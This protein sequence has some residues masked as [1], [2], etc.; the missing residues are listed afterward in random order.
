MDVA[1]D[2]IQ[3]EIFSSNDSSKKETDQNEPAKTE[4]SNVD[5][6][7]E[8]QETFRAFSASPWGARIGGL[9]DNVRKQSESYYEGAR[10]E[11]AAASEEAV[12]GFSDLRS[13]LVGRTRGLSLSTA[14]GSGATGA[15]ATTSQDETSTPTGAASKPETDTAA[16]STE[17]EKGLD[18]GAASS[19]SKPGEGFLS[20]FKAEAA[21]RLKEIEK[22]EE[23]ADEAILRFGMNIGQK[24]RE[25]V[26]IVPPSSDASGDKLL[27]ESKDAEGKRV[28]HATRFEAQL[29]VIH[30]TLESFTND[31]V[32][33]LWPAFQTEFKIAEKTDA[34]AADLEKYPELR[35]AMEKLVPEQVEYAT[36]W[37]RY[38]FL[39]LVIE[40]EEQ[41]RK[42][43]LQGAT[44][45]DD[46][47][48]KWDD[49]SDEETDSPSTPQVKSNTAATAA[50]TTTTQTATPVPAAVTTT[51]AATTAIA[52]P[53]NPAEPRRSNDQQSQP[54][55]ESSYDLV[56]GATSRT[57]ASPKE[58]PKDDDSD[59]DWE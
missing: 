12:K 19:A 24:L 21:R 25:A 9:W 45:V 16:S 13:S 5:L 3:E 8:L 39:R 53:A 37:C 40:T 11:Y 46:E 23:A 58:K 42:E 34:I 15:G 14:F 10:Q 50:G 49:D 52:K 55:S 54:D 36:F 30:S 32:S 1:Y 6:N 31:P 47:E 35:S 41:K 43:L 33:E 44:V 17:G 57:P 22:A 26:S 2:H 48:V 4:R 7:A 20:R 27:F 51:A 38:Y 56:S 59:D 18:A 28:I 29:H